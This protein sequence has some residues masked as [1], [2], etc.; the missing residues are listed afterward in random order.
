LTSEGEP[1]LSGANKTPTMA[2]V[3]FRLP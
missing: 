2:I 1:P 3:A